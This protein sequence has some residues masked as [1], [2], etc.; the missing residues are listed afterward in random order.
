MRTV[1]ELFP[2]IF[3]PWMA[4]HIPVNSLLKWCLGL[5]TSIITLNVHINFCSINGVHPK[6][7]KV[8]Q[9]FRLRQIN[10]G[11]F[12]RINKATLHMLR[13]AEPFIAWG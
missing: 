11:V 4:Q 12:V 10:N 2:G 3:V 5:M 13:I 9:L 8:M 7:R 1:D 6:P